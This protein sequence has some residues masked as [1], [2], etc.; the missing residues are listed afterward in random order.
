MRSAL[1]V[2]LSWQSVLVH[3]PIV[4][5]GDLRVICIS[6]S[7]ILF[8]FQIM[9]LQAT[10][11]KEMSIVSLEVFLPTLPVSQHVDDQLISNVH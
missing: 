8:P 7:S 2:C 5:C 6:F 4:T 11:D 9:T 10:C 3:I 1:L